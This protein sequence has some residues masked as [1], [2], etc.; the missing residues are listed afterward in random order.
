[1]KI[2]IAIPSMDTVPVQFA[3]SLAML[4]R[5]GDCSVAF[6][7]GSLVYTARNDLAKAAIKS[8]ADLVFWLDSDM[9]FAP[10]TLTDMVKTLEEHP[11][12]D[13]L[14]GVYFRRRPPYSPVLLEELELDE[15]GKC[16]SKDLE[17][18]PEG[19]FEVAGA[20]FGCVLMRTEVL[21]AIIAENQGRCFDPFLG[22]G[23]DLS[24]CIRAR[25]LGY[26][27]MVDPAMECGHVGNAIITGDVWEEYRKHD[28]FKG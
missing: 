20:G 6:Q 17:E 14:S 28:P 26:K 1:M 21:M 7:V 16:T 12:I 4:Q 11:E 8:E 15:E 27:V 13:I 18:I 19:L 2:L 23:E 5:T 3:S 24:F 22:V 9:V 10:N 25:R